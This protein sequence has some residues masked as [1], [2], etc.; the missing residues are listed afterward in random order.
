MK[1]KMFFLMSFIILFPLIMSPL[2]RSIRASEVASGPKQADT[3]T[4][5]VNV[6]VIPMDTERILENQTVIVE[7]DQIIAIGPA[8]EVTVPDGAEVI[9]GNG[10]YLMPGLADMHTH[11]TFDS[12]PNSLLLYLAHGITTVRNLNGIPQ[13]FEWRE[14]VAVGKLF[15]PTILTSGNGIYGVPSFLK[16]SVLIFRVIIV[17]APLVIGVLVYLLFWLLAKYTQFVP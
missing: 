9:E 13:H 17:I 11:L 3:T 7:G 2:A 10:A 16:G 6:N 1:A 4:A 15:G 12:D 5:F 14:Q 8:A